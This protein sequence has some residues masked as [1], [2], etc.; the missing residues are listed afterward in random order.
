MWFFYPP[1]KAR[2]SL[3]EGK[4]FTLAMQ[5]LGEATAGKTVV[6]IDRRHLS[7]PHF[8][9]PLRFTYDC[10]VFPLTGRFLTDSNSR[11][12]LFEY[13]RSKGF[14]PVVLSTQPAWASEPDISRIVRVKARVRTLYSQ[15]KLPTQ[16]AAGQ[17]VVDL[18]SAEGAREVPA[19]CEAVKM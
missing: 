4:S 5:C 10:L 12:E 3:S 8:E 2:L 1:T 19:A 6:F 18:Y 13:F 15:R 11:R 7:T 9:T 16:V 17:F 14:Q